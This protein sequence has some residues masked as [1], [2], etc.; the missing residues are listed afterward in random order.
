MVFGASL[1]G[2]AVDYS[3]HYL[4]RSGTLPE[5]EE[6]DS[7]TAKT[8]V[9]KFL[10]PGLLM[11]LATS[12]VGFG[13]L[14]QA[15][16]PGLRQ[17]AVFS[18][19]GLASAWL[20]V[21]AVFPILAP[22]QA[23]SPAPTLRFMAKLPYFL[24]RKA[25]GR[26]FIALVFAGLT[27]HGLSQIQA[28]SDIRLFH[29]PDP[30][31]LGQQHRIQSLLPAQAPNQFYLVQAPTQEILLQRLELFRPKLESLRDL[32]VI[33]SYQ[34]LSDALPSLQRQEF[35]QDLLQNTVYRPGGEAEQ[36]LRTIGFDA[37]ALAAF[38]ESVESTKVLTPE[39]WLAMAPAQLAQG[40]LGVYQGQYHS[41]VTLGGVKETEALKSTASAWAWLQ[42]VD[43]VGELSSTLDQQKRSA[44]LLLILAYILI[45]LVLLLRY[46]CLAALRLLLVP[47]LASL[48][49]L[50]GL[51]IVGHAIN[52]FHVFALFLVLGLGMDYS[53]FNYEAGTRRDS[54]LLAIFLSFSTSSLSFGL[55][56]L[57]N[58]PMIAAFGLM[59]FLGS[60]G[61]WIMLPLSGSR[62]SG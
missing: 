40:W 10:L 53:I 1:I 13:S 34:L 50:A 4:T 21:V 37:P 8:P 20:F 42:F 30:N 12:L 60:L 39:K 19:V 24:H 7:D 48:L 16:L 61:N 35:T 58:T 51:G 56:A 44:S 32:G 15:P 27:A 18:M 9:I 3:L 49:A 6:T 38:Q 43:T 2:V 55:L 41:L 11:A 57:S 33:S 28:S 29:T 46:R 25:P 23:H 5:A 54:C 22:R 62:Y 36:V 17:M 31:L 14:L 26:R 59:V 52:L 45:G 47:L